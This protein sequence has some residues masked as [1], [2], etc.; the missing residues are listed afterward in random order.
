MKC[1][2]YFKLL[3]ISFILILFSSS[4]NN[5]NDEE[6]LKDVNNKILKTNSS[7]SEA[8]QIDA[9]V[10]DG[11]VTLGGRC[12]GDNCSDSLLTL[13]KELDGVKQVV[14]NVTEVP[15]QTDLTLRTSIQQIISKYDGV[16]ADVAG[17]VVVLRGIIL[18]DQ[19][20]PLM[21][22]LGVLK[23]KKIDNQLAIKQ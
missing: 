17:G 1:N 6:I 11:V 18:R 16:Q 10:K 5:R 20:Q 21:N 12:E 13:V 8:N 3:P 4:C 14:N 15:V 22:E 23:P 7:G 19:I 9:S 2:Y